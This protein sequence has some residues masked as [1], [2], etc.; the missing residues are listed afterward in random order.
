M[1]PLFLALILSTVFILGLFA[2]KTAH[3][4]EPIENEPTFTNWKNLHKLNS[5]ALESDSHSAWFDIYINTLAKKAYIKKS[6]LLPV[7]SIIVKP[8]YPDQKRSKTEKLTIMVKK[9]KGYDSK[10]GDWWYGVY[11]KNGIEGSHKGKIKACIQC[12]TL[13]KETDYMFSD[14]IVKNINEKK[15]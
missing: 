8:L 4:D 10:N 12:H 15:Q 14:T 9:E 11:D 3:S 5:V 6:N 2:S 7:G 13:V 1:K